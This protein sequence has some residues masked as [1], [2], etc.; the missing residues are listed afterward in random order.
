MIIV[1]VEVVIVEDNAELGSTDCGVGGGNGDDDDD[2]GG[3]SIWALVIGYN[4]PQSSKESIDDDVLLRCSCS[5]GICG[6]TEAVDGC[7]C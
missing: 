1:V 2:E 5:I 3:V 6:I 4:G 7:G